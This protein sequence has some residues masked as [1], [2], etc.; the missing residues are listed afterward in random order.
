MN[1]FLYIL[2]KNDFKIY[3][4]IYIYNKKMEDSKTEY[5]CYIPNVVDLFVNS[6]RTNTVRYMNNIMSKVWNED[7]ELFIKLLCFIRDPRNGKGEKDLGYCMLQFLKDNFPKTY[8]KNIK[9]I[10]LEYG[11]LRDLLVMSRYKMRDDSAD[12][13]LEIFA[14][15]LNSDLLSDNP[16][17]AIKWAPRER[18]Q[19]ND[20]SKKLSQILFPDKKNSLELY[21]KNI[22]KPLSEKID[23]VEQKMSKNE[24]NSIDYNKVPLCS[25][26]KY[27]KTL[28]K[29][30]GEYMKGAFI[31]NDGDKFNNYLRIS[32]K[33]KGNSKCGFQK[34]IDNISM[35]GIN[36][37]N[38][39]AII[40]VLSKYDVKVSKDDVDTKLNYDLLDET[41]F[42]DF[43]NQSKSDNVS[44]P[45]QETF[46]EE[47]SMLNELKKIE[48]NNEWDIM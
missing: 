7:P 43:D 9:K 32:K 47:E 26:K 3:Q 39:K 34:I 24:W 17:L 46:L 10:A 13:E 31:R 42:D 36:E 8:A 18:N 20:L 27:G 12:L 38:M 2:R 21:R 37:I 25:I 29:K 22:L 28:V 48:E 14:E 5:K 1:A 4:H 15:I 30:D 41:T 33:N 35:N 6:S 23:I 45:D 16:T 44:S 11:C 40:F 19:Y